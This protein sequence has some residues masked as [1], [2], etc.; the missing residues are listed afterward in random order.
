LVGRDL[1]PPAG[2]RG[3]GRRRPTRHRPA[4]LHPVSHGSM[5]QCGLEFAR[6]RAPRSV[7]TRTA[8]RAT[9]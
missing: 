4:D 7:L 5:G 1:H 9:A 8:A 6:W 2:R 3:W